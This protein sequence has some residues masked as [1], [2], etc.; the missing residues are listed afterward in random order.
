M[1]RRICAWLLPEEGVHNKKFS[2]VLI[3]AAM[4]NFEDLIDY[5]EKK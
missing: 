2:V 3:D 4:K 5:L 1:D